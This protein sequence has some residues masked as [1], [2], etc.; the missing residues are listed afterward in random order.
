MVSKWTHAVLKSHW[1]K[2]FCQKKLISVNIGSMCH[3]GEGQYGPQIMTSSTRPPPRAPNTFL[4]SSFFF[5]GF[6]QWPLPMLL[7]IQTNKW[8][9]KILVIAKNVK[10]SDTKGLTFCFKFNSRFNLF[11]FAIKSFPLPVPNLD[12]LI[13]PS[14][15][16]NNHLASSREFLEMWLKYLAQIFASLHCSKL[17]FCVSC[18][19]GYSCVRR[20]ITYSFVRWY[21]AYSCL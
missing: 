6:R 11:H 2:S 10:Q 15:A 3:K 4:P 5:A 9:L 18:Y 14:N 7:F 17:F 20:Y 1:K 8:F 19:I 13:L 21:I 16:K 12:F